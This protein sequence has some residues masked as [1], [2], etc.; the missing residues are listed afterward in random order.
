MLDEELED[1]Q[2][3]IAE[4]SERLRA[5]ALS[6]EGHAYSEK[7]HLIHGRNQSARW[8]YRHHVVPPLGSSVTYRL[9]TSKLLRVDLTMNQTA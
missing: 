2:R 8:D 4:R 6:G 5:R 9:D 1:F 7:T 3:R